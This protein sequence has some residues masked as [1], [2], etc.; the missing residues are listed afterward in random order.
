MVIFYFEFFSKL[1]KKTQRKRKMIIKI[2][3]SGELIIERGTNSEN[4]DILDVLSSHIT[5]KQE[6]KNFLMQWQ[7]RQIIYGNSGLC[8]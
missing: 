6:L 5:D 4:K 1:Y 3:K 2:N 8:G 7:D